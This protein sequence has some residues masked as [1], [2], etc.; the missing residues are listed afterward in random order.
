MLLRRLL[1]WTGAALL[2][3]RPVSAG[4][5]RLP[6]RTFTVADG[7]PQIEITC[8]F[9]D[10]RGYLWVGTTDGL[11]RFDGRDFATYGVAEG[12]PHPV[13]H[14]I[15]EGPDGALWIATGQVQGSRGYP[16]W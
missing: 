1:P 13:V 2:A 8:V 5:R 16:G 10:R 11:A 9:E 3:I 14:D 7:L 12:L 15:L 6:T 4:A